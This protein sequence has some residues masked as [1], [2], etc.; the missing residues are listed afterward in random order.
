MS[1][2]FGSNRDSYR[3]QMTPSQ[4]AAWRVRKILENFP[5]TTSE[6]RESYYAEIASFSQILTMNS[7]MLAAALMLLFRTREQISPEVFANNP[8]IIGVL[9]RILPAGGTG[10]SDTLLAQY[11]ADLLRYVR[12]IL[13]NR[14]QQ[15][16]DLFVDPNDEPTSDDLGNVS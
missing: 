16:A 15:Q 7:E 9:S 10:I 11:K 6:L 12:A 13:F 4:L 8:L 3:R 2:A 5:D 1:Q 14:E